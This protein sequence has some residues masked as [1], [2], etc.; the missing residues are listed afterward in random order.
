MKFG[1]PKP[2]TDRERALGVA[3]RHVE[4][5]YTNDTEVILPTT[6]KKDAFFPIV[7][8][9]PDGSFQIEVFEGDGE[10]RG[11][12]S[13]RATEI[14]LDGSDNITLLVADWYTVRHSIGTITLKEAMGDHRAGKQ[15]KSPTVIIFPI[16][17][18]GIIGELP[19][20]RFDLDTCIAKTAAGLPMADEHKDPIASSQLI[21]NFVDAWKAGDRDA[22]DSML[23]NETFRVARVVDPSYSTTESHSQTERS[24]VLDYYAAGPAGT[25]STISQH[26]T[27]WFAVVEYTFE[28]PE[29]HAA[30]R[31]KAIC[32]YPLEGGKV[33]GE[34]S[35]SID[36]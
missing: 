29:A 30:S 2:V 12:Y 19:W 32:L 13:R 33:L 14:H 35:Y 25:L 23:G 15:A 3:E 22:L 9:K 34:I 28:L 5:E 11:F 17:D 36:S 26:I 8:R 6:S 21:S 24:D 7:F 27:E 10:P 20:A 16:A 31:R 4:S 1:T 18:D